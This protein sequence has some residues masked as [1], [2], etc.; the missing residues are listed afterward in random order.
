M[1]PESSSGQQITICAAYWIAE[2]VSPYYVWIGFMVRDTP[3]IFR[4]TND[5]WKIPDDFILLYIFHMRLIEK[6]LYAFR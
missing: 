2:D 1:S 3:E 4:A 5:I 6:F